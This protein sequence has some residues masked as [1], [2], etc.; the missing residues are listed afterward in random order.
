M[1][2]VSKLSWPYQKAITTSSEWHPPDSGDITQE[3][4][5]RSVAHKISNLPGGE[6]VQLIS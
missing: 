6:V 4:F 1:C 3:S 5:L 2:V